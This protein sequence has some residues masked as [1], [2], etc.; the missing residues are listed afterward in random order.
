M[1]SLSSL[2]FYYLLPRPIKHRC[3][4]WVNRKTKSS[5]QIKYRNKMSFYRFLKS[6]DTAGA[7]PGYY[8]WG[9]G[10]SPGHG[11][12]GSASLCKESGG[13]ASSGGPGAEPQLGIRGLASPWSWKLCSIWSSGGGAKFD[14]SDRFV[15]AVH[16]EML[17]IRWCLGKAKFAAWRA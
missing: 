11:K 17:I 10:L 7:R 5:V 16:I 1:L 6:A 2:S 4:T 8:V 13:K 3:I 12:R 14:T 9:G 15:F